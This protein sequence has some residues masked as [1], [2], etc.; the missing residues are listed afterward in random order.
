[1]TSR[2]ARDYVRVIG[3]SNRFCPN[4][5]RR[6][7][8]V[9][10]RPVP[11]G[12]RTWLVYPVYLVTVVVLVAWAAQCRFVARMRPAAF[13]PDVV[14]PGIAPA[15][16]SQLGPLRD[17]AE[18][19]SAFGNAPR[20]KPVGQVR[21]GAFGDSFTWGTEVPSGSDY[22][23]LLGERAHALGHADVAVLNFG[24]PGFG[25]HQ[26]MLLW[27]RVGRAY[28]LDAVVILA[29][30]G[31]WVPRDTSFTFWDPPAAKL[32]FH[33]RYVLDGDDVRL[34]EVL[35]TSEAERFDAYMRLV[36]HVRYARYDRRPPAFLRA[37]VPA[38]RTA[39]N[40]FY[41]RRGALADEAFATYRIL[42]A[43]LAAGAGRAA[44]A[45]LTGD[46]AGVDVPGLRIVRVP[47]ASAFP[48]LAPQSHLG[49]W[50]NRLV[51]D[52]VA[53][54]LGLGGTVRRV[55]LSPLATTASAEGG[56]IRLADARV[57]DV[58]LEDVRAG[59]PYLYR[60]GDPFAQERIGRLPDGVRGLA[61]VPLSGATLADALVLPLGQD[62][63][64]DVTLDGAP[65]AVPTTPLDAGLVVLDLCA[66]TA[67]R[68]ALALAA[69]ARCVTVEHA[70][71]ERPRGRALALDVGGAP[72]VTAVA[73][74]DGRTLFLDPGERFFRLRADGDVRPDPEAL[75]AAGRVWLVAG[76]GAG[77]ARRVPLA[78]F[79]V[80]DD[81]QIT[82]QA[83]TTCAAK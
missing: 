52:T 66:S 15:L 47:P 54:V 69:D 18:R 71:S 43:R 29:L 64:P 65:L 37:W 73:A 51:A 83:S 46:L 30:A 63:V 70:A 58:T 26:S 49:P 12:R 22:P 75:P 59:G 6:V 31:L 9:Y 44:V 48:Y 78:D 38:G 76:D 53:A 24:N 16:A 57:L 56:A 41:Y 7:A 42:L 34:V 77:A 27:E 80:L 28:D 55:V 35:G 72:L 20:V 82:D 39:R 61:A 45:D 79:R 19:P 62:G 36:P 21:I 5:C 67:L 1:M 8:G 68:D 17:P 25:M 81:A 14:V 11:A 4:L 2:T 10:C 13:A 40:P 50:G 3:A 74:D 23:A 32:G 33:A 60:R